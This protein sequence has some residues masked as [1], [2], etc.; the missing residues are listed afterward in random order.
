M[1]TFFSQFSPI[2]QA[3]IGTLFTWAMTAAG[4]SAVFLTKEINRKVL[5]LMLG[6]AGGVILAL[7][8]V[9][10]TLCCGKQNALRKMPL[11]WAAELDSVGAIMFL[12]IAWLGMWSILGSYFFTNYIAKWSPGLPYHIFSAGTIP[13]CNIAIALK[14]TASLFLIF[15]LLVTT[16]VIHEPNE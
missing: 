11:H 5:D 3:L 12:V 1:M 16:K 15:M 4:A 7:V 14:V 8:F 10:M 6:F 13:L 9:L 2:T